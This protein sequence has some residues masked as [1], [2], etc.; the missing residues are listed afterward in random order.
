MRRFFAFLVM[1]VTMVSVFAINIIGYT[2]STGI[3]ELQ[4]DYQLGLDYKGGY[5]VLYT[6]S[7]KEGVTDSVSSVRDDA[8]ETLT[9]QAEAAGL[10]DFNISKEGLDQL[11]VTFPASSKVAA[12]AV[13]GLLESDCELSFRKTDDTSLLEDGVSAYDALL[14]TYGDKA[15]VTTDSNGNIAIQ[16]NLS[17]DGLKEFNSWITEGDLN[18]IEDE[19]SENYGGT[20]EVVIWF[21]YSEYDEENEEK[22]DAYQ[23]YASLKE[24]GA[25]FLTS[26]QRYIYNKYQSKILS[27]ATISAS[28]V[29]KGGLEDSKFLLTGNFTRAKANS[30]IDVINNGGLDYNLERET[31]ARIPATEGNASITT[32]VIAL[33]IGLLAISIFL[34]IIYRLPG[35]GA[36]FTLLAQVG[37][38]LLV[39]RAF[40]GLFG[41]EVIVALLV[42]VFVGTDTFVCL[43]ERA[44]D[45]MYKGKQIERSFD[46]ASKK[47]TTTLIDSTVLSLIVALIIFAV[48]SGTI[49]SI[50]TM[51]AVSMA[52]CLVLTTLL[53]KL[54]SNCIFK[55]MKF[56]GKYQYFTK[57]HKEI[58]D[59]KNGDRQSFFGY[60]TNVNFF[61]NL[62]KFFK[63]IGCG[64]LVSVICGGVWFA[65]SGSPLNLSSELSKYT[66]VTIQTNLTEEDLKSINK[67]DL[68]IIGLDNTDEEIE[69]F[70]Y[71]KI[72]DL[73]GNKPKEVY[74]VKDKFTENDK[75]QYLS[76]VIN[77][78]GVVKSTDLIELGDYFAELKDAANTLNESNQSNV[79]DK[80][81]FTYS[82]NDTVNVT[83]RK[84]ILN[85][86]LAFGLAIAAVFVYVS[87]RY[88]F[89]YAISISFGLLVDAIL[90]L[91]ALLVTHLEFSIV[92]ATCILG[93]LCYSVNDKTKLFDKVREN[94]NGSRKKVFTNEELVEYSNKAVQQSLLRSLIV[95]SVSIL[96]LIVIMVSSVFNYTLFTIVLSLG[97]ISSVLTSTFLCPVIW[98]YFENKWTL[99]M[100]NKSRTAKKKVKVEEL[101]EQVFIGIND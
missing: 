19:E 14:R 49:R 87:F 16:L 46:E 81:V 96:M 76:C 3:K 52:I 4:T 95:A 50:A 91:G 8:I 92:S 66:K 64:L 78:S 67:G 20:E 77:F 7:P 2:G 36:A 61:N 24:N 90:I 84:T 55:S 17:H 51:L 65:V 47:S 98:V 21:G 56:E 59:V 11:R 23:E 58:P 13:L 31:F 22:I 45:E 70:L 10:S 86:L 54:L 25:T 26:E 32:T 12:E 71:N 101:E 42:S 79:E 68:N 28:V 85:A 27:V 48:G 72:Y 75:V 94:L 53:I 62:K 80:Y 34:V 38:S 1:I 88:K 41:P 9:N 82:I 74:H 97:I 6:I 57:K 39:Y 40:N 99:F 30:I 43:F 63:F 93:I 69:N 44:K 73:T 37:L 5:E 18:K 60:F 83:A 33:V 100:Q 29:E 89:T 35:V 15:E